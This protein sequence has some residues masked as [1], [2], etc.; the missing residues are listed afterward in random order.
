MRYIPD[1]I[2]QKIQSA[3]QTIG[4]NAHPQ[5]DII[6][7]KVTKYLSEG[8]LLQARTI[9]TGNILGPLDICIRRENVNLDPTEIIMAYIEN[10]SAK[11]ATL[12]YVHTPDQQFEYKYTVGPATDVACDFDGRWHK[13]TD[14]T[15]I[16]FDTA[17]RWALVT[18][19]EPYIATVNA[20][21]LTVR[22]GR[23]SAIT[24]APDN[25]TKCSMLRGWKNVYL[26]NHDQGIVVAYIRN[27]HVMY[28][29]Y[30]QQP[31]DQPALWEV[32]RQLTQFDTSEHPAD[33]ISMFRANDYRLGF[34]T[35]INGLM[36]QSMT[37][38][39]WANMAIEDEYLT[40]APASVTVDFLPIE[41]LNYTEV[42]YL[43]AVPVIDID[44][45]YTLTDNWFTEIYNV[46][47]TI[48]DIEDWGRILIFRT[49]HGLYNLTAS[50]FEIVDT[51]NRPY[52]PNTIE[53]I[54][55][56]TY[57]LTYLDLNN[58]NNAGISPTATLRY[59]GQATTNAIDLLYEPF[60]AT[61][62]PQNLEPSDIPLPEVEA[63]WNE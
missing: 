42:E 35:S 46:P 29:N 13:I 22:Q 16:Y 3:Y 36:Y 40:A 28:R 58:F 2:K 20:G 39:N 15:G 47:T 52:T 51:M 1:T 37:T 31:P 54:G 27:G 30:C 26:W 19:G 23:G 60:Q 61:F 4:A 10:G 44:L 59:L 56:R 48:D 50:D 38:R 14:R 7:Q 55:D 53:K 43:T 45:G 8:N 18:F 41:Y 11:V 32:E 9:R 21:V 24:L 62:T 17:I 57:R 49:E 12:P 6:A 33:S 5:M 25:V 63:I 34:D